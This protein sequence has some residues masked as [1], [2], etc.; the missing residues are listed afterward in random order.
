MLQ[1]IYT[2]ASITT[3]IPNDVGTV[4]CSPEVENDGNV[5]M[6]DVGGKH[7]MPECVCACMCMHMRVCVYMY[8]QVSGWK[9]AQVSNK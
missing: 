3:C 7:P 1:C 9:L 4:Q 5:Y 8:G 2:C 6:T